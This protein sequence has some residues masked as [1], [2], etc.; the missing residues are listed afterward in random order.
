[1]PAL[2]APWRSPDRRLR[3]APQTVLDLVARSGAASRQRDAQ[4]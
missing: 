1:M 2:A 3:A 4:Q